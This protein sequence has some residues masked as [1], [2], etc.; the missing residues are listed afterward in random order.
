MDIKYLYSFM[1]SLG[2]SLA[3]ISLLIRHS[4]RVGLMDDPAEDSRKIHIEITPRSGGLGIIAAAA[5]VLLVVLPLDR[6][7]VSFLLSCLAIISFGLLDDIVKLNPLQK[8]GG[9][10][11]GVTI[12]MMGGMLISNVPILADCPA[13]FDYFVTFFFVMGVINGVNFSDGMDG[14]AAGMA[15]MAL[16]FILLL[17]LESDNSQL[18]IIALAISASLLGFLRYN[19]HPARIFMGDAG[20]QF[21]GFIICWLAIS[22]SQNETSLVTTLMPVLILGLPVMDILQV[23]VVRIHKKLPL[24]GPDN[25]HV[26]HQIAKLGFRPDEVVALIYL[27]QAI[28][29]GVAYWMRY[30]NDIAILVF[31]VTYVTVI[32]GAIY[33]ANVSGWQLRKPLSGNGYS[34]RAPFFRRLSRIHRFTGK[35]FGLFFALS[36]AGAA[37]VSSA[38]PVGLVYFALGWAVALFAIRRYSRNQWPLALGR[39]ATYTTA[40]LLTYGGTL[41]ITSDVANW[42]IDGTYILFLLM[43]TVAIRITRKSYFWLTT[44][45]LLVLLF[46]IILAPQLPI[47]LGQ[48][49]STGNLIFRTCSLLYIC[50]YVLARGNK[51]QDNITL[52]AIFALFL[53]GIHL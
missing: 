5:L 28:L 47:D 27:L 9:Q 46:I 37:V 17:A 41:S 33:S 45:D 22:I 8:L 52:A 49:V 6:S 14:L 53:T 35:F 39:L 36:M 1:I 7:L 4:A 2:L 19:T 16:L 21:L 29:L 23:I 24:P 34:R 25:E 10:A 44:Q 11:I 18:A 48:G 32:L 40:C 13:W 42:L 31:Y 38:L 12:A 50:E 3:F 15:L 30:S 51:A 26:H 20:S 43:F